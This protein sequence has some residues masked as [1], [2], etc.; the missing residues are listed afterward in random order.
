M[1]CIVVWRCHQNARFALLF[2]RH[3]ACRNSY[4]TRVNLIYAVSG[5]GPLIVY[6]RCQIVVHVLDLLRLLD[7]VLIFTSDQ[8]RAEL[9]REL[10][11]ASKQYQLWKAVE[12]WNN[13]KSL[14]TV[15]GV[16]YGP[17]HALC[18]SGLEAHSRSHVVDARSK[19]VGHC[20]VIRV[21][22]CQREAQNF[23]ASRLRRQMAKETH[24]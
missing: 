21:N 19:V 14:I 8:V 18:I 7:G 12:W 17:Q 24:R 11:W 9:S 20:P 6:C 16:K 1:P 5:W 22:S 23:S 3:R 15:F 10:K 2:T 4:E 13:I